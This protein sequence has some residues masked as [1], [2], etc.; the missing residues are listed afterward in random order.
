MIFEASS[1]PTSSARPHEHGKSGVVVADRAAENERHEE[2]VAV[3][4]KSGSPIQPRNKLRI[5]ISHGYLCRVDGV[6][7]NR[8]ADFVRYE[9]GITRNGESGGSVQPPP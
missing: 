9:E 4:G 1:A 6:F 8:T 7:A 5:R 2:R 3:D